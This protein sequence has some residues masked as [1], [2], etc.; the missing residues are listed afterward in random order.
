MPVPNYDDL[1]SRIE[2]SRAKARERDALEMSAR[3]VHPQADLFLPATWGKQQRAVPNAIVRC[4]LV[5]VL[6]KGAERLQLDRAE[7]ASL[8]GMRVEYT[9]KQWTSD[10]ID[11]LMQ[12]IHIGRAL[13]LGSLFVVTGHQLL[14]MLGWG[15]SDES[16]ER[17]RCA[18][19]I[20]IDATL[21]IRCDRP[22]KP[23]T[24]P[25][26]FAGR[27][28]KDVTI[29]G[30][31]AHGGSRWQM[32]IDPKVLALFDENLYTIIE[33]QR[34]QGLRSP[35]AKWL[36]LY[37]ETHDE[38]HPLSTPRLHALMGSRNQ[39]MSSFRQTLKKA[40]QML[41]DKGLVAS[42]TYDPVSDTHEV[43]HLRRISHAS[44]AALVA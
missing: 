27:F 33:W 36:H 2:S 24:K 39:N 14:Q 38:P 15:R 11:V 44:V 23:H 17:V 31:E 32:A 20:L 5:A 43:K 3:E 9:G 40:H 10:E 37:Y 22:V 16:Y 35:M 13:P 30:D 25:L 18:I 34:R 21:R 1:L 8:D 41:M 29:I 42:A 4:G 6:E 12:L 26:T 7:I 28:V 19:N